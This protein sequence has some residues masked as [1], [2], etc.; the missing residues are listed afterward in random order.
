MENEIVQQTVMNTDFAQL[1]VL[2]FGWIGMY[3][4]LALGAIGSMI[5]CAIVGQAACGALLEVESGYGKFIG[6]SALPS[7]QAI[8]GVVV[9]LTLSGIELNST[10]APGIFAVGILA[11]IA[12]LYGAIK[13]G[14]A[15]ASAIKVSKSKPEVFG[16]SIAPAG[17]V[18]G[19]AI[20]AFIFALILSANI[21]T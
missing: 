12:L 18:E 20:F 6:V 19:F 3:G 4:A 15:I 16:L 13:Q 21:P 5:G 7:S 9:T 2:T 11:G 8:Y 10:S 17:I 1:V 14:Q